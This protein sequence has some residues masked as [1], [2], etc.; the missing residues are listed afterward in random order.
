MDKTTIHSKILTHPQ[1]TMEIMS[2]LHFLRAK[3]PYIILGTLTEERV[4]L[5]SGSLMI[6]M[7][8]T[9]SKVFR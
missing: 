1:I 9:K 3:L 7:I 8:A 4:L 6:C 5:G 2:E